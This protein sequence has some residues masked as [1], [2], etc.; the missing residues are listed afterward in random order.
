MTDF[1]TIIIFNLVFIHL[2][3]AWG[4]SRWVCRCKKD[5]DT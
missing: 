5:G 1:K 3:L 4:H 2:Y